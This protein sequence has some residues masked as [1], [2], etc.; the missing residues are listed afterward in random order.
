VK[1]PIP[2]NLLTALPAEAKPLIERF[3]LQRS[4]HQSPIPIYKAPQIRLAITGVGIPA[5]YQ[6]TRHLIA[7]APIEQ[8]V[9]WLNIGIC[10]HGSCPLGESLIATQVLTPDGECWDLTIPPKLGSRG[11]TLCCVEQPQA[12]YQTQMAYDMESA[13]F[14]AALRPHADPRRIGLLKIVSDNPQHSSERITAKG[15]RALIA[16]QT[17][18]IGEMIDWLRDD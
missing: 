3:G 8:P 11:G 13:G 4:P 6:A 7:T 9:V 5:M 17:D 14:L 15:V 16:Q 10:G 18:L 1:R 12:V 2:V